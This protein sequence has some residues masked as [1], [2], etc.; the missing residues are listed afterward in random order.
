[1]TP[2]ERGDSPPSHSRWRAL[3]PVR[4]GAPGPLALVS[5]AVMIAVLTPVFALRLDTSDAG[6][7]ASNLTSRHAFDLLAQGFGAR[8]QRTAAASSPS[9]PAGTTR[10]RCRRSA[11][12]W[13]RRPTS[14]RVSQA[15]ERLAER[16][17][18]GLRGL[19]A[20]APQ[21]PATMSLVNTLRN[22]VLPPLR[23]DRAHDRPRRRLHRRV[24][25]LLE[26]ARGQ[27]AAVHRDRR[28]A[29]GAA[30]ARDVPLARDRS[31]GGAR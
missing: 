5:L 4:P 27:A 25:R 28:R 14:S 11:R 7:D 2:E 1:M 19:P 21:A 17:G 6:N 8:L 3:E 26:R 15:A 30:A 20:S 31:P 29:L 9:C 24:D 16:Q 10:P 12:R 22:D 18:R 13:L 23:A